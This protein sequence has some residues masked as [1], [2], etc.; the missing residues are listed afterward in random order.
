VLGDFYWDSVTAL[1]L[2]APGKDRMGSGGLP[3]CRANIIQNLTNTAV[4]LVI[5]SKALQQWIIFLVH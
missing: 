3:G 2:T 5:T 1:M 4:D